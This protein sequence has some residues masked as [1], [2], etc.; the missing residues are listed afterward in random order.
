MRTKG[1]FFYLKERMVMS[2]KTLVLCRNCDLAWLKN[3][4]SK[5]MQPK[6]KFQDTKG[7]GDPVVLLVYLKN[8][9]E[10]FWVDFSFFVPFIKCQWTEHMLSLDCPV[11]DSRLHPFSPLSNKN[12][13][14]HW[15]PQ[16]VSYL[17]GKMLAGQS[18]TA[19]KV[20]VMWRN[21][22]LKIGCLYVY[23]HGVVCV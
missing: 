12:K 14:Y 3:H 1:F 11:G 22:G 4:T 15:N 20:K 19:L 2:S 5:G 9:T 16:D 6:A 17:Y 13:N 23:I 21:K 8:L 18:W 7:Y 10:K